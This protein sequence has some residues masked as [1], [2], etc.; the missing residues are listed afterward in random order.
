MIDNFYGFAFYAP[1]FAYDDMRYVGFVHTFIGIN[2]KDEWYEYERYV[3]TWTELNDRECEFI[4]Y[5]AEFDPN[6]R[7]QEVDD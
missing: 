5:D 2:E 7:W 6:R 1:T 4:E 3:E